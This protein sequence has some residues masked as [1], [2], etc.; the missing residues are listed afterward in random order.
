MPNG[1]VQS[2]IYHCL[3]LKPA[4]SHNNSHTS[5]SDA[6]QQQRCDDT[7]TAVSAA[8][9]ASVLQDARLDGLVYLIRGTYSNIALP[10]KC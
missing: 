9:S 1:V 8:V 2:I 10:K 3:Q 6:M 7:D 5:N 4:N